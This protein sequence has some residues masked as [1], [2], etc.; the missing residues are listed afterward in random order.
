MK[1]VSSIE[2]IPTQEHYAVFA[3]QE[4]VFDTTSPNITLLSYIEFNEAESL[5]EWISNNTDKTFRVVEM[6]PV[7]VKTTVEL[8]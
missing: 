8:G 4:V 1:K 7:K 2:E 5:K 6:H 3:N